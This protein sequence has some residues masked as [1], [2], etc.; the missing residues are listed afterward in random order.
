MKRRAGHA[1]TA[2]NI[3]WVVD[4]VELEVHASARW[5]KFDAPKDPKDAQDK[6]LHSFAGRALTRGCQ[7]SRSVFPGC[8]NP[9]R[10]EFSVKRR[11]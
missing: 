5:T 9:T 10:K 11:V 2:D 7:I 8:G 6:S 4:G 3:V 1:T